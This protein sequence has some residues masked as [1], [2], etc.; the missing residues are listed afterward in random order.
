MKLGEEAMTSKADR[1]S[2]Q[3]EMNAHVST[4]VRVGGLHARG[5]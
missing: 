4:S 3:S 1:S 2:F 5:T